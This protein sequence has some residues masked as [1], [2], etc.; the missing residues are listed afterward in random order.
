M[1]Y[2]QAIV[3]AAAA[4][5]MAMPAVQ[6]QKRDQLVD[7][8]S[9]TPFETISPQTI[10]N[11]ANQTQKAKF[12]AGLFNDNVIAS[13]VGGLLGG[14]TGGS[15]GSECSNPEIRTE[16][17][18]YSDA[19]RTSF[20][21]AIVCL[22]GKPS[23]GSQFPGSGNRYED[24]TSTHRALS[25]NIHQ[26]ATFLVWHRYFVYTLESLLRNE[27]GFTAVMPWWDE[28]KYSGNFA[29]SDVFSSS[30]FGDIPDITASGQ[31][32]CVDTGAFADDTLHVGPGSANTNHCLSRALNDT[33]TAQVSSDY[34]NSCMS[35]S[36]YDAFR[37]CFEYGPHAY[38]HNG[39]GA[40]MSDVPSSVGDPI[41]FMHHLFVDRNFRVWQNADSS[42]LTTIDG[43]ADDAN[44]CTPISTSTVLSSNGIIANMTVGEV[45]NTLGGPLCY[46]YDY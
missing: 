9:F 25:P 19:D 18:S 2:L 24:L 31:G 16:W 43:C 10:L 17:S 14:L 7:L 28:T 30:W 13:T 1:L 33:D 42:R 37:S 27:C 26:T 34:V 23:G 44:P 36:D 41:F 40:V 21:N 39:I 3:G 4:S 46:R 45:L 38:G 12:D 20:V 11:S 35:Q 15:S 29:S 32:T 6:E 22:L 8:S 5:A